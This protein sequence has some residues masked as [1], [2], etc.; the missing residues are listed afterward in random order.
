MTADFPVGLTDIDLR[1]DLI[2]DGWTDRAIAQRVRSGVLIKVR[3]GAY[4]RTELVKE[5]DA[6]QHLRVRSRA[7]L[8]TTHE[9]SVLADHNA[10]AEYDVP[11]WG[12]DLDET[13]LIRTDGRS[14]RREAGV[15]HHR[16]RLD[17]G[18]WALL[19]GVPVVSAA[20]AAL[21]VILTH[22]SEVGLVAASGVLAHKV[23]T[24]DELRAQ[25]DLAEHWPHSLSARIVLSRADARLT[26]VGEARAWHLFHEQRVVRPEPQV[27]VHDEWGDLVG[28]V[29]FLW[30]QH[31]VFLEFDGKI[32]Y[33]K[34]RRPGET[35]DQYL[36]REKKREEDICRLTGWVCIRIGWAHLEDPV[37]TARRI[38]A[39]LESRA[40][41][42]A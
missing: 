7:V 4:V 28:I 32:K 21:G 35:L 27:S 12:V 11:L 40:K 41:R 14:G 38:V 26:S 10:L 13:H 8:R 20:R 22:S 36:M 6:T 23:A 17:D 18:D 2:A 29:D 30:R 19:H 15:V 5:F 33:T 31:G 24:T 9:T 25:V 42:G 16:A 1:R 37:R 3:Y 39:L 34:Y